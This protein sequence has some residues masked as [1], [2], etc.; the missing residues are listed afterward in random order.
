MKCL[1]IKT[2]EEI[3]ILMDL[4]GQSL[5]TVALDLLGLMMQIACLKNSS[6]LLASTLKKMKISLAVFSEKR[7]EKWDL[8]LAQYSTTMIFLRLALKRWKWE[9]LVG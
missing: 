5:V 7:K 3:M 4:T 2:K 1:L 9:V 6:K 8:T